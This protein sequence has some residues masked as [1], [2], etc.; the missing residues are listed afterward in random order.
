M[1]YGLEKIEALLPDFQYVDDDRIIT[2]VGLT[3]SLYFW[4]GHTPEK[5]QA[6]IELFEAYEEAYGSEL[7]WGCDPESWQTRKLADK[8]FPSY[9][10][11]PPSSMKMTASSGTFLPASIASRP[12][13]MRSSA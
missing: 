3:V 13:N 1:K 5:R 10:T 12:R 9:A 4:G 7:K 6:I 8:K 2:S 11:T